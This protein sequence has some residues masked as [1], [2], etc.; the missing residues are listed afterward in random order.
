MTDNSAHSH[1]ILTTLRRLGDVEPDRRLFT[2]VNETGRDQETTTAGQLAHLVDAAATA[3]RT[4]GL[5]PGDRAVLVYPPS[6]EFVR[7]FAGCVAAGV[8]PVPVYPPNPLRRRSSVGNFAA[9]VAD[10]GASA[11][12]TNGAYHRARTVGSVAGFT[13]RHDVSWPDIQWYRTDRVRPDGATP[14]SWHEPASADEPAF[15]QYTSGSTAEPRGVIITH[16]NLHAELAANAR[17]LGLGPSTRAVCWVPQYHDLGLISV[18][19]STLAGNGH[20]HLMSPITF[21]RRPRV[22]FDVM[23]RVG[24]THTAAPNFAFEIAVRKTTRDQRRNWDLS[25]LRVAMSAGEPIRETTVRSFLTAFADAGLAPDAF[26]GA[27]GLAEHTVSVSMG[28]RRVLRVDRNEVERSVV[29]PL[30]KDIDVGA[31]SYFSCGRITKPDASVVIVDPDTCA[32]VL[33][34]QVGE[35][36]VDSPTKA[37]GY[38]G[39]TKETR[40][41]FHATLSTGE[42]RE[43]L[44]TGDTGFF[45]EDEL[46]VVGR[47]KDLIIVNGRNLYPQDIENGVRDC[48]PS[49]RPGGLAAF[50]GVRAGEDEGCQV[51]MFVE[52]HEDRVAAPECEQIADAVR[53][54]LIE[55][56]QVRCHAV[57]IGRQGLVRKPTSGK[58][59]RHA[60]RDVF[61]ALLDGRMA[62]SDVTVY[63]T[64]AAVGVQPGTSAARWARNRIPWRVTR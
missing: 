22:W 54:R 23:S 40:A 32:L 47:L 30:G 62:S 38:F 64:A 49:I 16:G 39:L 1:S 36:W 20:S 50:D 53:R 58:V 4:W 61:H 59:R 8:V 26:Y 52:T 37:A 7:A 35:I 24:A 43:Y 60:C 57:V 46:F 3:L 34:G 41:T 14:V 51:V 21:L 45:H 19:L 17:D 33:P 55:E 56:F 2:F 6:L 42:P 31:A 11:V 5:C 27:Y 15:L 12:L 9:I 18:I 44:R 29:A 48:H 25:S 63:R 10:S 28:G 13:G